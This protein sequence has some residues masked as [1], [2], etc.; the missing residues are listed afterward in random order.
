VSPEL[1]VPGTP[2]E[3]PELISIVSPELNAV[4]TGQ[5]E[6]AFPL[7]VASWIFAGT[8]AASQSFRGDHTGAVAT[9]EIQAAG[10]LI[11]RANKFLPI[12]GRV[13][14]RINQRLSSTLGFATSR[15]LSGICE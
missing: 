14:R 3:L 8:K 12:G 13:Q 5:E 4:F 6:A 2:P 11:G 15:G 10:S 1:P 9:I 7:E